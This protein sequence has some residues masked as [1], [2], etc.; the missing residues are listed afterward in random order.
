MKVGGNPYL[1]VQEMGKL[2]LRVLWDLIEALTLEFLGYINLN[3]LELGR[4]HEP[5]ICTC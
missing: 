4:T 3:V 1:F 5:E 2:R